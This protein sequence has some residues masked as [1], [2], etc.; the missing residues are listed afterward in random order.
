MKY[1]KIGLIGSNGSGKSTI[2]SILNAS[3]YDVISLSDFVREYATLKNLEHT[4]DN[5]TNVGLEIKQKY[6]LKHLALKAFEKASSCDQVVFDSIRNKDE[7]EYLKKQSVFLIG[8][9]TNLEVRYERVKTRQK[10][11]D[12]VSFEVFKK[13]SELEE[14]GNQDAQNIN[15][16]L[17]ICD[18]VIS[19]NSTIDELTKNVERVING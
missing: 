18:V 2:C 16:A 12:D 3:G 10:V 19:N 6:G 15:Q 5:L 8:V 14:K 7:A 9:K 13:Q 11:T 17:E 4:R 1:S